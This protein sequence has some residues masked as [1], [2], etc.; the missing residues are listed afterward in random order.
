MCFN[1]N[2][3]INWQW[4]VN[5][6]ETFELQITIFKD[7]SIKLWDI[8]CPKQQLL[9]RGHLNCVNTIDVHKEGPI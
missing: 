1:W 5:A 7:P 9:M 6:D 3:C 8:T 2:L 4:A